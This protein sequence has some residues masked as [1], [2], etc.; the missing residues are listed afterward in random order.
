M[1][2]RGSSRSRS[3]PS[4]AV[5]NC[6]AVWRPP[7]WRRGSLHTSTS[8]SRGI[9]TVSSSYATARRRITPG[10]SR[11]IRSAAREPLTGRVAADGAT[12]PVTALSAQGAGTLP[13]DLLLQ[14]DDRVEQAF[15]PRRAARQIDVDRDD[16]VDALHDRVVVEHAPAREIGR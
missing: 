2:K 16:L 10:S 5:T 4:T 12:G 15:G 14:L 6:G 3:G 11:A 7:G 13:G 8:R 9:H 1:S